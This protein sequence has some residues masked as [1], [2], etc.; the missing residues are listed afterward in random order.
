MIARFPVAFALS[1]GL[2]LATGSLLGAGEKK[3]EPKMITK[4]YPVLDLVV[5]L[6][7][8]GNTIVSLNANGKAA[9]VLPPAPV[10]ACPRTV[11]RLPVSS[12]THAAVVAGTECTACPSVPPATEVGRKPAKTAEDKLIKLVCGCIAPQ[13]WNE[14]GG[15]GTIQFYPLGMSIVVTQTADVQEQIAELLTALRR[16]ADNQVSL[17]VRFVTVTDKWF[18]RVTEELGLEPKLYHAGPRGE[19][20]A[21]GAGFLN[22]REVI[23]LMDALQ[24]SPRTSVMQSPKVTVFNGMESTININ[25]QQN[26]VT[27]VRVLQVGG[28]AVHVPQSKMIT[29]GFSIAARPIVSADRRSVSVN[30]TADQTSI[31][32]VDLFPITTFI[33]PVFEGGA[34]GQPIPFTNFIQQ[35]KL[36]NVSV[37]K[38]FLVPNGGTVLLGGWKSLNGPDRVEKPLVAEI[39]DTLCPPPPSAKENEMV[40]VMVTPR[41][42]IA[43]EEELQAAPPYSRDAEPKNLARITHSAPQRTA[44]GARTAV[45][46]ILAGYQQACADGRLADAANLAKKALTIDPACFSQIAP[47][48]DQEKNGSR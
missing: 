23:K 7:E 42:I 25:D 17:E 12:V 24:A 19:C 14:R 34:V 33:T 16:L 15:K 28:Q 11:D 2:L 31:S 20:C 39:L 1:A 3:P 40:I 32:K 46:D 29:T 30:L 5:P 13:S 38:S 18:A 36:T 47:R 8:A 4:V 41:I 27:D 9:P 35:P 21:Q 22:E 48:K 6:D 44:S 10:A 37:H 45:L 43:E 26:F